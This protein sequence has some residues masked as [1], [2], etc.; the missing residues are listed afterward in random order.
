M[1]RAGVLAVDDFVEIF[2]IFDVCRSQWLNLMWE[3]AC[4][5][6]TLKDLIFQGSLK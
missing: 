5:E 6:A 3:D 1:S 4:I 2:R